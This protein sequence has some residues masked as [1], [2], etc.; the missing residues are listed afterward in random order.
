MAER[1]TDKL[2][3]D[4]APPETGNRVVYD[5]AVSGFGVRIT[6]KG[7]RSFILN[8]RFSD[9]DAIRR[10]SE[11]R[12]TI[13]A[14]PAWSVA[15]ARDEAK[16]WRQRID[17]GEAHPLGARRGAREAVKAARA[18]ETYAEAVEDYVKR[19][20]EGRR[21]NAT[22][23]EVKRALLR[24][25]AGWAGDPVA[26]ITARDVRKLLEEIRD[27][28]GK[29]GEEATKPRPYLANR[30]HAY[31][32]LFFKWCAEPGIEKVPASPMTGLRRPWEGEEARQRFYSDAEIKGLWKAADKVGGVGGA[33]VKV[34]LLTG[35]RKT[36]LAAM[37]WED[38]SEDGMWTPPADP[39]RRKRNKR[40]HAVPLPA[41]AMRVLR[42]LRP[43]E[44]DVRPPAALVS[45]G[46]V[47]GT[48]LVP[49]QPLQKK[50]V[51]AGGV[52]DFTFHGMRHT[53]ETRLA[54][55]GVAPHVRDLVLDHAP[56]RGAGAGYDH[57]HYGPEMREALETW[58][59]HVERVVAPQGAAVL[60]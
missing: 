32:S 49:G 10:S 2:V 31:L 42:P 46:R 28:N 54:E 23:N 38:L 36:A 7:A 11:Y 52:A 5:D 27:G 57:H 39:R 30:M 8:Y 43:A 1:I 25:G 53:V 33:F 41:L 51:E 44:D 24:E 45:P 48:C 56:V 37:R 14:Y 6:A 3:R 18:A 16:A 4:L 15:A 21:Q 20:Q 29:A 12:F 58:A 40:L 50:I 35:K 55:L 59:A 22:A 19:E 13:G 9:P 47:Q 26:S 60:R 17:R 34:A